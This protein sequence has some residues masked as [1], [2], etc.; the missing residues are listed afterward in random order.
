MILPPV[1]IFILFATFFDDIRQIPAIENFLR[2]ARPA[3]IALIILPCL[4]MWRSW[5]VTLSTIWIPICTAI[6]VGL[7][8]VSP[9]LIVVGL[10]TLSFIYALLLK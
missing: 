2:G 6:A 4:Q 7:L 8:G 10:V 9:S 5:N 1:L 3:I